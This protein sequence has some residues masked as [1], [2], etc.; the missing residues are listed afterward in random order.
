MTGSKPVALPL[1]DT[2]IIVSLIMKLSIAGVTGD[3]FFANLK[4]HLAFEEQE[5][6]ELPWL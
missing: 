5:R 4:L 2:P 3:R 6:L 1:G